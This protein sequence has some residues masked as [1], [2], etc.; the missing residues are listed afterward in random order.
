MCFVFFAQIS[1]CWIQQRWRGLLP[2][3]RQRGSQFVC[4]T[5]TYLGF[6]KGARAG[7]RQKGA[8]ACLPPGAAVLWPS[9]ESGTACGI[10]SFSRPAFQG[11]AENLY[12]FLKPSL[13]RA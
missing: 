11:W 7:W 9:R 2:A 1:V 10:E 3:E 6:F 5:G 4:T 13:W 8:H 12:L